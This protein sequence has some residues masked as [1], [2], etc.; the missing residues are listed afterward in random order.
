[1]K[2]IS[3]PTAFFIF[4]IL[5]G[6][7]CFKDPVSPAIERKVQFVLYTDK[8][9]TNDSGIITFRLSIQNAFNP[10]WDSTLAPMAIKDIPDS[11][12][13]IVV[14]KL[15]PFNDNSMLKVGFYYEIENVGNSWFLD[16]LPPGVAFKRVEFNFR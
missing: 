11:A 7:S 14:E 16:S 15:V 6:T 9:F 1:M 13:K 4:V 8:D 12:H 2:F 5:F 3:T 10:L